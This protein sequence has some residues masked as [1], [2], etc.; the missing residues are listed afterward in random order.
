MITGPN[1][2]DGELRL[3]GGDSEGL[4]EMCYNN[5]WGGLCP[6]SFNIQNSQ[7]VC[8][9]LGFTT[10]GARPLTTLG[11]GVL[12]LFDFL[13]HCQGDESSLLECT[14]SSRIFPCEPSFHAGVHCEGM[15]ENICIFFM[16]KLLIFTFYHFVIFVICFLLVKITFNFNFYHDINFIH[17]IVFVF[18]FFVLVNLIF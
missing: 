18:I 11:R 10:V 13:F 16:L 8:T 15:L 9:Q 5:T 6:Y 14:Y 7:V 4:V 17:V 12:S 2:T 1:C 3:N